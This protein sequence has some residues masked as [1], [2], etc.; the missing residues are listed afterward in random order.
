MCDAIVQDKDNILYQ[1]SMQRITAYGSKPCSKKAVETVGHLSLCRVHARLA[2]E[3]LVSEKGHVA[4]PADI[5]AVRRY[6]K[7]F[8]HGMYPWVHDQE[9]GK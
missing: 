4:C 8:P 7:K 5:Q 3:G 2:R 6:P 9:Q 1:A